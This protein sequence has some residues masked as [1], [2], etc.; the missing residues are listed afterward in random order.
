MN[1]WIDL[2]GCPLR[3]A[4]L[5]PAAIFA[6]SSPASAQQQVD[7]PAPLQAL[8]DDLAEGNGDAAAGRIDVVESLSGGP[9]IVRNSREFVD[10]MLGCTVTDV[11]EG[12]LGPDFRLFRTVMRCEDG[13]Y[14]VIFGHEAG[15]PYVSIAE[16]QDPATIADLAANPR[17]PSIPPP[18]PPVLVE[19]RAE[20]TEE[21]ARRQQMEQARQDRACAALGQAMLDGDAS[22][23]SAMGIAQSRYVFGFHDPFAS[24]MVVEQDG[25]GPDAA[26]KMIDSAREATG[27]PESY[28]CVQENIG[29]LVRWTFEPADRALF[30]MPNLSGSV[31]T[32]VVTRYA[33]RDKLLEA[34]QRFQEMQEAQ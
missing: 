10:R 1:K 18:A 12:T 15:S 33:T 27:V 29:L 19:Q 8:L 5:A 9:R 3:I 24:T 23:L 4:A 32:S 6:L 31:V 13:D 7:Y 25:N 21:R 17:L 11:T 34:Q 20:S 30:A 16:F 22:K 28:E 14:N 26:Q 2:P